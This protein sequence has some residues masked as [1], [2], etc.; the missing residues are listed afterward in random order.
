MSEAV[1]AEAEARI[2]GEPLVAHLG[3]CAEG[4]PHVAPVWYRYADGVVEFTTTGRK[5]ADIRGN[6]HVALSIQRDDDG[7]PRWM[8]VLRGTATV[9]DDD[10]ERE[11]ATR[12][13]N[14][15]Y[16]VDEDAWSDNE[17]VRVDVGSCSFHEYD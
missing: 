2:E 5:L 15:K 1:P 8:A 7:V 6:S 14:R 4:R 10:A 9:V 17:L 12:R 11:A 16:G 13:I 3:T